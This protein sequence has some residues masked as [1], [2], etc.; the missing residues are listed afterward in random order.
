[1]NDDLLKEGDFAKQLAEGM[2]EFIKQLSDGGIGNITEEERKT[3]EAWEKMLIEGMSGLHMND[4]EASSSS[5]G[6]G[7]SSHEPPT[8]EDDF[9][10]TIQQ[11][12]K[13]LK[14][15]DSTLQ[16]CLTP[17]SLCCL[18]SSSFDRFIDECRIH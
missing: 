7:G 4:A 1:M 5:T 15:S 8:S 13:K 6:S 3:Q 11:A 12:M 2:E 18:S 10:K 9:Q 16:V 14:D 17:R